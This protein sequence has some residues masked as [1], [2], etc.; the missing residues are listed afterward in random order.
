[1][2]N[3]LDDELMEFIRS[4]T[5]GASREDWSSV[6]LGERSPPYNYRFDHVA[7]VARVAQY[8]ARGTSADKEVIQVAAWLHDAA[9]PSLG[10]VKNHAEASAELAS[11]LLSEAGLDRRFI[12]SVCDAI[13]KHAGLTLSKPL[14]PIEAQIIWEADKIV[15]LGAIGFIHYVLN[16]IQMSAGKTLQDLSKEAKDYLPLAEKIA[17]SMSTKKG[18]KLA[19]TRLETLRRISDALEEELDLQ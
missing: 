16:S 5:E 12:D 10:G 19:K 18:K 14:E 6:V 13:R 17:A 9:K 7:E 3:T 4:T 1:M 15:K 2:G 11:T 8:L